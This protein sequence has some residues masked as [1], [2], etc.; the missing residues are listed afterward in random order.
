MTIVKVFKRDDVV[1]GVV[2]SAQ[3]KSDEQIKITEDAVITDSITKEAIDD[4]EGAKKKEV[5]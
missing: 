5:V 3:E 2:E 1:E 4:V